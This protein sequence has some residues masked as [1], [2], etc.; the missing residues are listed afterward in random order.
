MAGIKELF[1]PDSVAIVGAS[2]SEG[3]AGNLL[4]KNLI[5]HGYQ[6]RIYPITP[7]TGEVLGYKAYSDLLSVPDEIDVAFLIL[8]G[9]FV[10]GIIGQ[11]ARKKVKAVVIISAGFSE[12]GEE[13]RRQQDEIKELLR[14][15]GIR[16]IGPNTIGFV[17]VDKKIVAS[18]VP[19]KRWVDGPVALA[20]QSGIFAGAMADEIMSFETQKLGF[21]KSISFGNKIDLDEVDFLEYVRTDSRVKLVAMHLESLMR[22][23][24]FFS[25]AMRV[26]KEKPIIVLKAGRTDFGARAAASHTGSLAQKDDLVEASFRQ[27]GL[28]RAYTV[29]EFLAYIKAF[30]YQPLPRGKKIGVITLSGSNAVMASDEMRIEGLELA[31]YSADTVR[32]IGSLM[33]GWPVNNPA[34]VWMAMGAG[35]R[36]AHRECL[37]AVLDDGGVDACLFIMIGIKNAAFD[38]IKELFTDAMERHPEKPIFVVMLGGELKSRWIRELEGSD[39]PVYSATDLAVKS[40]AAMYRYVEMKDKDCL[41]PAA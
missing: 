1:E 34:D 30:S 28:I 17:N 37:N 16:A 8:P 10:K 9:Q 19:L 15:S 14:R 2:S 27:Y 11:C 40:M 21:C 12:V 18:F 4:L 13:G 5:M 32:R 26:K 41:D 38:G 31:S 6:G 23:R 25:L 7:H 3:K 22:P 36:E 39:V 24:E 29:E 35:L 20:A 33:P